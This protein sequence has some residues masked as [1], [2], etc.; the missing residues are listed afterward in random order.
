MVKFPEDVG[1]NFIEKDGKLV[2][3][4][5]SRPSTPRVVCPRKWYTPTVRLQHNYVHDGLPGS[6]ED[7]GDELYGTFDT[8]SQAERAVENDES[9]DDTNLQE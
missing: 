6:I 1:P 8:R 2:L 7:A 9:E 4:K 3:T 5:G